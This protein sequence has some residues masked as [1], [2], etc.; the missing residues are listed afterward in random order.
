MLSIDAEMEYVDS[1]FTARG[2][3]GTLAGVLEPDLE[4]TLESIDTAALAHSLGL[5][6]FP[7]APL[8]LSGRIQIADGAFSM[9]AMQLALAEHQVTVDGTVFPPTPFTGSEL[10]I[11]L[12]SPDAASLGRLF[13]QEGLPSA[14]LTVDGRIGRPDQL[15]RIENMELRLDQRHQARI[16]GYVNP[17]EQGSG[18]QLD[19]QVDSP[20]AADLGRLFGASGLPGEPLQLNI[21]LQPIG[22][23][24]LSFRTDKVQLGTL[25][26]AA[27]GRIPDLD[28]PT[29]LDAEFDLRLPSLTV[30]SFLAPEAEF[31]DLPFESRGRLHHERDKTRLDGVQLSIGSI[32]AA[33]EGALNADQSFQLAVRAE[34]P[35]ASLLEQWVG[36]PL[37]PESFFLESRLSGD[38]LAIELADTTL[39][40]G[41]SDLHANLN[42]GLGDRKSV[43]GDIR[44][45]FL[46]LSSSRA[47]DEAKAEEDSGR[48]GEWVLDETPTARVTDYGVDLD[49]DLQF[50]RVDLGNTEILDLDLDLLLNSDSLSL[51]PFSL[52]GRTGGVVSGRLLLD[53]SNN[54]PQIDFSMNGDDIRLGLA[55]LEEQD[56]ET[57]PPLEMSIELR[58]R[59]A[60]QREL[61][62]SMNGRVRVFGGE[63]LVASAGVQFL[64]TDFLTELFNLLNP[65]A[66]K[67][68]FTTLEC[69]VFAADI[70]DGVVNVYPVIF[71]MQQLTILS[72]GT[73]DLNDER[74]DLAFNSKPRE[75]LGLSAG[76]L[77]NPLIKVG[78]RL[79]SPRIELDPAGTIISGGAAVATAGLSILAKTFSDRFLSSKDPCGDAR[80]E[81]EARD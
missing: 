60:T 55:A 18:S 47:E 58:G 81:L 61:A 46:D 42:I 44:S 11:R 16:N 75:G 9:H 25:R 79:V 23:N 63:G 66:E 38:P 31:P 71:H 8:D 33:I 21:M 19:I 80:R 34:G 29:Q 53:E 13:G 67:N 72:Q 30:L 64:L 74:I 43:S 51:S 27:E 57:F 2:T 32:V 59:G 20:D 65:F 48:S 7:E 50:A 70:V 12:D 77:I 36:Q 41:Q 5:D 10:A 28:Q 52:R 26:L 78:G 1:S 45:Q 24:G 54:V 76:A 49:L 35:D 39:R 22:E 15:I 40:I 73:V 56:I 37:Q 6:D 68:D 62:S 69:S 4:I 17:E 14:P 3:L